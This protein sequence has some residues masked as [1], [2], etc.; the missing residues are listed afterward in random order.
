MP[1]DDL[2]K[3]PIDRFHVERPLD[4][5][6]T[7]NVVERILGNQLVEEPQAFLRERQRERAAPIDRHDASRNPRDPQVVVVQ[8]VCHVLGH[9]TEAI[10]HGVLF[11]GV[12][13][14]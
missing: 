13:N 2:G 1:S 8:G 7:G 14:I 3:R 6:G 11:P 4:P 5:H 12:G 10:A 9:R